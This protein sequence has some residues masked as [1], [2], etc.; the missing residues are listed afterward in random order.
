M[1]AAPKIIEGTWEEV[2]RHADEL[3]GRRLKVIVVDEPPAYLDHPGFDQSPEAVKRWVA[4][5]RQRAHSRPPIRL[6]DDSRD[7]I[8]EDFFK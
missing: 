5:L 6:G 3:T 8:Y 4:Q 7:A 2:A 1:S